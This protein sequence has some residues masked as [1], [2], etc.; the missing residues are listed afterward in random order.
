[1]D[2]K[3]IRYETILGTKRISNFCWTGILFIGGLGFLFSGLSSYFNINLLP[4]TNSK[5]LLFI[6]Q[7]II[8]SFYGSAA[9]TMSFFIFLTIIWDVGGGYNEFNKVEKLVKIVRKGFPGKNRTIFLV[10]PF[11]NVR[12]IKLSVNDGLNPKRII[13]LCTKD[14][15]EIPLNQ[16]E[17][18]LPL[19]EIEEKAFELASFLEV[20]LEGL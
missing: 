8:M 16:I 19:T 13:L 2:E 3:L 17:Q 4:F 15:R 11:N 14:E 7:G 6:P 20:K 9:L 18:P 1:M 10:Y 5:E 12:S